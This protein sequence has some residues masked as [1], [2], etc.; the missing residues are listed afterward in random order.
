MDPLDVSR[1]TAGIIAA[2]GTVVEILGPLVSGTKDAT[3]ARKI[4][5]E[6]LQTQV[7]LLALQKTLDDLELIP[8]KRRV[9]ILVGQLIVVLTDGVT[10]FSELEALAS[11]LGG[12]A[13]FRVRIQWA[14]NDKASASIL[15]R[16]QRFNDSTR[17]ISNILQR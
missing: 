4:C 11:K 14:V 2:A 12:S 3:N 1:S 13:K 5:A 7:T 6:A 9:L 8:Q 16:I 15:Q 17:L 10:L